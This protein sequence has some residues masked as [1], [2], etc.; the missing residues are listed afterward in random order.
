M[1][2][3]SVIWEEARSDRYELRGCAVKLE[4]RTKMRGEAG[5]ETDRERRFWMFGRT[6]GG[7]TWR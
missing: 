5:E 4:E 2:G 6:I 3:W 1:L 7:D